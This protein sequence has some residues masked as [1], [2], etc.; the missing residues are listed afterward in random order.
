MKKLILIIIGMV[1]IVGLVTATLTT[2]SDLKEATYE[3]IE[4][5]IGDFYKTLITKTDE[6]IQKEKEYFKYTID[7][8]D[9]NKK[10]SSRDSKLK[11][12]TIKEMNEMLKEHKKSESE[13]TI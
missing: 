6:K 1:L 3:K 11:P 10:L 5:S 2:S 4:T 9:V 8:F 13:I 12:Y 7:D